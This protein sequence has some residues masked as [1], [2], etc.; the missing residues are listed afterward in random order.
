MYAFVLATGRWFVG[1]MIYVGGLARF[2]GLLLLA[3]PRIFTSLRSIVR[4]ML[5]MGVHSLPLIVLTSIFTGAVSTWQAAYQ[6]QSY[7]PLRFLGGAVG[8]AILIE[9]APVLTA[10]VVAGR[11]GAAIAAQLGTMR[12]TEQIDALE[13]MGI[14]PVRYLVLPRVVSGVVM[15]PVLTLFANFVAMLGALIVAVTFVDV[16]YETFM[17]SFK[18]FFKDTDLYAG[19]VK[20][21]MFGLIIALIGCYQG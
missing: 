10:L 4:Q 2:A 1:A 7:V 18:L 11:V 6:F 15:L 16:T 5:F 3:L 20:A 8:K 19:L 21:A 12:V 9:L 14:D 13:V 17:N